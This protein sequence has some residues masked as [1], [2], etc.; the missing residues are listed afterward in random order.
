[1]PC[2]TVIEL[3]S[4]GATVSRSDCARRVE[5]PVLVVVYATS[6]L[7]G[8]V[9]SPS[10]ERVAIANAEVWLKGVN[11]PVGVVEALKCDM[12]ASG[13]GTAWRGSLDAE[14]V[15]Q[16]TVPVVDFAQGK[17]QQISGAHDLPGRLVIS[18][19]SSSVRRACNANR[20]F[21]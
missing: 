7:G 3:V 18:G 1:M 19:E 15:A 21:V 16:Q 8:G 10:V 14:D 5:V 17:V 9:P 6:L 4:M 2:P 12:H 20:R 13:S 11:E